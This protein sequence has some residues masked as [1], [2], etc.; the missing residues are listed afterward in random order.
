M[1]NQVCVSRT[2]RLLALMLIMV[3]SNPQRL[4]TMGETGHRND[5]PLYVYRPFVYAKAR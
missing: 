5:A 2:C 1:H 4:A 3:G